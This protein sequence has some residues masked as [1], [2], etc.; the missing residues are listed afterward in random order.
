MIRHTYLHKSVWSLAYRSL[1]NCICFCI[2]I[3]F[4]RVEERCWDK[5]NTEGSCRIDDVLLLRIWL[6]IF[7]TP[8]PSFMSWVELSWLWILNDW[9]PDPGTLTLVPG[10][11]RWAPEQGH[12]RALMPLPQRGRWW[13]PGLGLGR[14][15]QV[16]RYILWYI[17]LRDFPTLSSYHRESE[18]EWHLS[19]LYLTQDTP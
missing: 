9:L 13:N 7:V 12:K 16:K 4:P 18:E 19:C 10:T 17:R 8:R 3:L 6:V 14:P 1:S 15:T 2:K 11:L 5:K